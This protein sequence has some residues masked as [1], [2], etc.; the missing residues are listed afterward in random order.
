M[1]CLLRTRGANNPLADEQDK[2]SLFA[3]VF[4]AGTPLVAVIS[5]E[6]LFQLSTQMRPYDQSGSILRC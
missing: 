2:E 5:A 1:G 4:S 3:P 6:K